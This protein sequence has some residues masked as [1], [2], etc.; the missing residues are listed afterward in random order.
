MKITDEDLHAAHMRTLLFVVSELVHQQA[1]AGEKAI[2]SFKR[3][4]EKEDDTPVGCATR[5][6]LEQ[7]VTM[8]EGYP[9]RPPA[10]PVLPFQKPDA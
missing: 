4:A 8:L 10:A 2:R 7:I 6:F 3:L 9:D 1:I 5:S